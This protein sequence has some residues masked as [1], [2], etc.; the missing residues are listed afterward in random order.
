ML[1]RFRLREVD[2]LIS[3]ILSCIDIIF[4]IYGILDIIF[5]FGTNQQK[6]QNPVYCRI[7]TAISDTLCAIGLNSVVLL[8]VVSLDSD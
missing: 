2:T 8:G 1:F 6:F 4:P 5:F 3:F 7:N